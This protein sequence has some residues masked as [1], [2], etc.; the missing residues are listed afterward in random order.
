MAHR[1]VRATPRPDRLGTLRDHLENGE[2]ADHE[3][4]GRAMTRSLVAAREHPA[5]GAVWVEEDYCTPPLAMER[6]VLEGY[7]T[8]VTVVD[9]D[10]DP[11]AWERL[12]GYP[13]VWTAAGLDVP[14]TDVDT[15]TNV[16]SG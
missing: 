13:S 14:A 4:F 5:G 1:L 11:S 15:V 2:I 12:A 8:G 9:S 10:V 3:P 16:L 6:P 7:F